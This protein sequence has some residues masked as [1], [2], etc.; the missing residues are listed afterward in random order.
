MLKKTYQAKPKPL[1]AFLTGGAGSGK[2][3]L[4]KAIVFILRDL[5]KLSV[6]VHGSTG[7]AASNIEGFTVHSL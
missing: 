5:L 3:T 7:V 1:N 4:V 6:L 2:T